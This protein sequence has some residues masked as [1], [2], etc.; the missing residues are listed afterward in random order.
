[1]P[2]TSPTFKQL[3]AGHARSYD[4]DYNNIAPSVGF[5]WTPERRSGLL[6]TLMGPSNDFVIRGGYTR[7][8]SR[9]GLNDFT[10]IF[11]ANP[12]IRIIQNRDEASANLGA[13]P[14]L[15]RDTARLDDPELPE[16]ARVSDD[17]R[18]LAGRQ[19]DRSAHQGA[20]RRFVLARCPAQPDAR[21]WRSKFATSAPAA[22]TRGAPT[23][24]AT[25][26]PTPATAPARSTSTSSTSS[27]TG[28]S[29]S[30]GWRSAT[31]AP[32]SR[33]PAR[34]RSP[35]PASPA[36]RRCRRSSH[37]S[38]RRTRPTPAT[39]RSTPAPTGRVRRS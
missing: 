23:S 11:G 33:P 24:T 2:G 36:R 7:S 35:I 34:R 22:M 13:T 25:T 19:R 17:R 38:M 26:A 9:A 21:T 1:M 27:R 12:G 3:N 15:L 31:C 18:G 29:T 30:S 37:S 4:T 8:Y 32:T 28:S 14:L 20:E 39:R 5:A 6:G 16:Q 10:A